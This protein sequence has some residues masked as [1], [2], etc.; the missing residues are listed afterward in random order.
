[1]NFSP[2]SNKEFSYT[3]GHPGYPINT[4]NAEYTAGNIYKNLPLASNGYSNV[5][6]NFST[7]NQKDS[8]SRNSYQ[9]NNNFEG[10]NSTT[11][12]EMQKSSRREVIDQITSI[13]NNNTIAKNN[14]RNF[15]FV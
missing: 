15:D 4:G 7:F 14:R 5:K 12:R 1:M 13:T 6:S 10:G 2:A 9:L 8:H 11:E 3:G